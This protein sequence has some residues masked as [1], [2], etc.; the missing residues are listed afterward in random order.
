VTRA[1]AG[2]YDEDD[3]EEDGSMDALQEELTPAQLEDLQKIVGDKKMSDSA[4]GR[5]V[6]AY[7]A[8][9]ADDDDDGDDVDMD[10]TDESGDDDDDE[11]EDP[12]PGETR[13]KHTHIKELKHVRAGR[14]G[15]GGQARQGR[16]GLEAWQHAQGSGDESEL[17]WEAWQRLVVRARAGSERCGACRMTTRMMRQAAMARC[18]SACSPRTARLLSHR[19]SACAAHSRLGRELLRTQGDS[20]EDED[21]DSDDEDAAGEMAEMMEALAK[22]EAAKAA[23]KKRKAE[24][25]APKPDAKDAKKEDNG[26]KCAAGWGRLRCAAQRVRA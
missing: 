20:D 3:D 17:G 7:L 19:T 26:K 24:A 10:T 16:V 14:Q 9:L 11:D 18:V 15:V 21:G 1:P 6:D 12:T 8:S 22:E 5:A 13:T 4:K 23:A 25:D 2:D